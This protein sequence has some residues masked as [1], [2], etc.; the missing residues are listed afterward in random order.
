MCITID[1]SCWCIIYEM[2]NWSASSNRYKLYYSGMHIILSKQQDLKYFKRSGISAFSCSPVCETVYQVFCKCIFGDIL[3]SENFLFR[4]FLV[5]V[6]WVHVGL[7]RL[8]SK[9][10]HVLQME[11]VMFLLK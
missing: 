6:V 11:N 3:L 8:R 1:I 10:I 2:Q 5:F 4:V 7:Q 9:C